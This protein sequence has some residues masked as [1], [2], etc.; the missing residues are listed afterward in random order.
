MQAGVRTGRQAAPASRL[1]ASLVEAF[2]QTDVRAKL[3]FTLAM[4]VVFRFIAHVP[5]PNVDTV[6]LATVLDNNAALGFMDIFSGGALRQ[7]S[8]AALG[9]YPY[10]SASII[11]T[12]LQPIIPRLQALSQEGEQ[13]RKRVQLYTHYLTVPLALVQGYAQLIILRNFNVIDQVGFTNGHALTT[14]TTLLS[15][16]AGTMFL[17]W[18]GELITEKGIGN[19]LSI[20][21]FGG[22]VS[23]FPGLLG[24][25][26]DSNRGLIYIGVIAALAVV[27]ILAIVFVQEAQRRIP[28][29]YARSM[30]RGGRMYRQSGQSHI[31]L[32]I[33]SAGMIP[34]IFA[35]SIMIFPA[36][37]AQ[38]FQTEGG[39]VGD[40]AQ[41]IHRVFDPTN[42]VYWASVFTLV[43]AFTYFYTMVMFQQQNLSENLQK[44]SGFIPGIRPGRPTHDYIQ[45][46]LIRIT[47]GG[48][49]FLGLMAI[50]P[51]VA[52]RAMDVQAVTISSTGLL[53]VVGV[54]LDT[55][56]QLEAQ[57]LMRNYEGF[58]R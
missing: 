53:I 40:V 52:T 57:L 15:F 22:I 21:I 32:R 41:F 9:V 56:R 58:I 6:Q 8:V 20:I 50:I 36:T 3:L 17:V 38:Y 13:G 34:L 35:Y 24:N 46:V 16:A 37:A 10:I 27:M 11:M 45:R 48:A 43:V 7:M 39:F 23:S 19:G 47:A 51:Y 1:L 28:V 25:V 49:I 5:V 30:F 31:P 18:L 29:Q 26:L 33:N 2:Q 42:P 12:L 54:V 55:M 4:L 44:Q 14:I